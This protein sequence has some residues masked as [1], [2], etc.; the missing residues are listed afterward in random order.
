MRFSLQNIAG[1][2]KGISNRDAKYQLENAEITC[3][4]QYS[5]GNEVLHRKAAVV[6][7]G[8][9]KNWIEKVF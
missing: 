6:S 7:V 3:E 5:I 1:C 9:G 8:N 4:Y 2:V